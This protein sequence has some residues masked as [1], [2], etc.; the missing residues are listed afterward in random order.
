PGLTSTLR[1][2]TRVALSTRIM[3]CREK[4]KKYQAWQAAARQAFFYSTIPHSINPVHDKSAFLINPACCKAV[5]PDNGCLCY[6]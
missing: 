2:D 4:N 1:F 3:C 5:F 6:F